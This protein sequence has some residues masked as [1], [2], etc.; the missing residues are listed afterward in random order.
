V[1]FPHCELVKRLE[2][3]QDEAGPSSPGR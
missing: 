3:E 1:V 2:R